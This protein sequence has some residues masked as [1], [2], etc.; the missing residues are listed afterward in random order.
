MVELSRRAYLAMAAAVSSSVAGCNASP[1]ASSGSGTGRAA[2]RHAAT[3]GYG[4]VP[5]SAA[6]R[7]SSAEKTPAKATAD[8]TEYSTQSY[9]DCGYG[10]HQ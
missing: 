10:G 9:G 2:C 7:V 1:G 6:T 3:Y 5:T 8:G 4:G